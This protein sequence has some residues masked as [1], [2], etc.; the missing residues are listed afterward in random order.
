M[1]GRPKWHRM[2]I[3]QHRNHVVTFHFSI[4]FH[5]SGR[6]RAHYG[7][8][9]RIKM[10]PEI[11]Q[12]RNLRTGHRRSLRCMQEKNYQKSCH[13][14]SEKTSR[15]GYQ[16]VGYNSTVP[17]KMKMNT[18]PLLDRCRTI[19]TGMLRYWIQTGF[20]RGPK[21][22]TMDRLIRTKTDNASTSCIKLIRTII[23]IYKNCMWIWP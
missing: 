7:S 13:K 23:Q 4:D 8:R 2:I 6:L 17:K 15:K 1:F 14:R 16:D 21:Y 11:G 9:W 19:S 10:S 3:D 22:R 5:G 18:K 20:A 12:R